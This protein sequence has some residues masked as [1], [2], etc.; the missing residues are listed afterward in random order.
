MANHNKG[1]NK[2]GQAGYPAVERLI[3][4]EDFDDINSA[5]ERAYDELDGIYKKKKGLKTQ[6]DAR[7]AMKSLEL[8]LDLF[9]ELLAIKYRLQEEAAKK[10]EKP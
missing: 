5:F 6:R 4:T 8:T 1:E 3:D 9:R 10:A 7:A 2:Y